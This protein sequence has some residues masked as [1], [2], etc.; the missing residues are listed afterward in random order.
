MSTHIPA[1]F[2][3]P[4]PLNFHPGMYAF[5]GQ[6]SLDLC[7]FLGAVERGPVYLP[8]EGRKR[9]LKR[10]RGLLGP[11]SWPPSC[12]ASKSQSLNSWEGDTRTVICPFSKRTAGGGQSHHLRTVFG[13]RPVSR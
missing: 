1:R 3:Q 11:Y 5:R 10:D 13:S 8:S 9:L 4:R 7:G 2:S 6:K 12:S